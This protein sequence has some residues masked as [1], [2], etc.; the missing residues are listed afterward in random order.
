MTPADIAKEEIEKSTQAIRQFDELA[1]NPLFQSYCAQIEASAEE[2][3]KDVLEGQMTA[4]EREE[5]RLQRI[6]LLSGIRAMKNTREGHASIL[7]G[8]GIEV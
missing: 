6:G 1:G 5:L 8:H 7:R 2:M 4:Q 3:G